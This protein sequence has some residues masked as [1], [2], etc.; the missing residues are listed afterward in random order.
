[1]AI[2]ESFDSDIRKQPQRKAKEEAAGDDAN[3][4]E[5]VEEEDPVPEITRF[6]NNSC[7]YYWG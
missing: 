5:D 7:A 3:M 6:A 4:K 1:L 2:R